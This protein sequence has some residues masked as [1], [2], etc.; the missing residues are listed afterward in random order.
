[1]RKT[2]P[3]FTS[4]TS[5]PVSASTSPMLSMLSWN[6]SWKSRWRSS[7]KSRG[8]CPSHACSCS[9]YACRAGQGSSLVFE[10]GRVRASRVT[11][12]SHTS[13][14]VSHT[15]V[16]VCPSCFPYADVESFSHRSGQMRE[17]RSRE[18][19]RSQERQTGTPRYQTLSA[20]CSYNSWQRTATSRTEKRRPSE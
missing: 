8:L 17:D 11:R 9:A 12:V 7:R 13:R 1:L 5:D 10:P 2:S 20:F 14:R 16:A 3:R 18:I 4:S 19:T 6:A 15:L